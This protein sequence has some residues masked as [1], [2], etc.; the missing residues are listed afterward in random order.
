MDVDARLRGG[1]LDRPEDV[2]QPGPRVVADVDGH[3]RAAAVGRYAT[4][5]WEHLGREEAVVLP[6]A[7]KHLDADDWAAIDA[8]FA[9]NAD[10]RFGAGA[11]ADFRHLL[12]RIVALSD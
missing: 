8:A 2:E 4:F 9:E 3:L 10:P 7:Q 11:D 12:S 6:A 1:G 5:L